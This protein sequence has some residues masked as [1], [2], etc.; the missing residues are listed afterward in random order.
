MKQVFYSF[1]TMAVFSACS[2]AVSVTSSWKNTEALSSQQKS[3]HSVFIS[4]LTA[5]Q[6]AKATVETSLAKA[7][8]SRGYKAVKSIDLFQTIDNPDKEAALKK[9]RE[10]GCDAI[11]TV[12]L[13]NKES[14]TRYVPG[15]TTY[16]PLP[17]YG[18]YGTYWGYRGYW[19][20][21]SMYSSPGYYTTDKTYFIESNLYDSETEKLLWSAQSKT[22]NPTD[23]ESFSEKYT[24][25]IIQQLEKDGLLKK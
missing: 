9:I 2:P 23:L 19:Y 18:Y 15:T 13:I 8:E 10:A 4:G 20:G 25:A 16:A 24:K 6:N 14:E 7:A 5:N 17:A 3:Y 12:A 11:F 22:V 21:S 1:V